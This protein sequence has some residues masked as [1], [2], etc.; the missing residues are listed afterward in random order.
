MISR[1]DLCLTNT[2]ENAKKQMYGRHSFLE[3]VIESA[4]N[5]AKKSN[6]KITVG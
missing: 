5:E 6:I 2:Q 4:V 1:K 3:Q